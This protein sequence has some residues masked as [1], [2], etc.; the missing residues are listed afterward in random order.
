MSKTVELPTLLDEFKAS[1][2]DD[3]WPLIAVHNQMI[4]HL[5]KFISVVSRD[6]AKLVTG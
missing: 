2:S 4:V 3:S 6:G 5:A 1:Y